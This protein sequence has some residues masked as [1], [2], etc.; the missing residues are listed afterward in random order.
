V[1][2]KRQPYTCVHCGQPCG[3]TGHLQRWIVGKA[4]APILCQVAGAT[5]L[6]EGGEVRIGYRCAPGHTCLTARPNLPTGTVMSAPLRRR[7]WRDDR[8]TDR[9]QEYL[10]ALGYL[11]PEPVTKGQAH[12]LLDRILN[13]DRQATIEELR[14][15]G[16]LLRT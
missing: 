14:Q 5:R 3:I 10:R 1:S 16:I 4:G 6:T 11:G 13:G 7:N 12:D 9:Q 15:R 2:T 8:P